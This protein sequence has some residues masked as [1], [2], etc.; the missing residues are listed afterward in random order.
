MN[1]NAEPHA[2]R[3]TFLKQ[4]SSAVIAGALASPIGLP[5]ILGAA[6]APK[7]RLGLISAATYG[8]MGAPRV[9]GSNHGT[10]FSTCCNGFDEAKRKQFEGRSLH[11]RNVS[12][13]C[14]W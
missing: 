8:Y 2:S 7:L 10:A 9:Q 13:A 4:S 1:Q 11:R 5:S 6:E 12:R 14:R 3:R